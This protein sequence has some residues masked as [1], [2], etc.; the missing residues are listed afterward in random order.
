MAVVSIADSFAPATIE[1]QS[2]IKNSKCKSNIYTKY[3]YTQN[4]KIPNVSKC[5]VI[6]EKN[7]NK[8]QFKLR[9][10]DISWIEFLEGTSSSKILCDSMDAANILFSARTTGEPKAIP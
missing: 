2:T 1:V 8:L 3:N 10:C 5:I 6:P 9:D 7:N 4:K